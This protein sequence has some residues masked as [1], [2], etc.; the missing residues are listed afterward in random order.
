MTFP[1][2]KAQ[3]L[4]SPHNVKGSKRLLT[5]QHNVG[6][7]YRALE[8]RAYAQRRESSIEDNDDDDDDISIASRTP[9]PPP[10]D[11][12]D[13]D[14]DHIS[15]YDEYVRGPAREVITV[16]TRIKP[17]NKGF[18]LLA[19]MG[20]TE[21]KPLGL[22]EDGR[23]DPIPF[24]IKNDLTGLGKTNQDVRM[25][26]T[27]VSQRRELDSERQT[28]ETEEQRRV[29][30]EHV[31]RRTAL[32]TEISST[33]RA[34]YCELCDKQFKNVAQYDEHTNSYAHHHKARLKDMQANARIIPREELDRRK[35]KERKREEKEL[36]KIAAAA[37]IKMPKSA[38]TTITPTSADAQPGSDMDVEPKQSGFRQAGWASVSSASN[39]SSAPAGQSSQSAG[40]RGG[41]N[42]VG[43]ATVTSAPLPPPSN[44]PPSSGGWSTASNP[45]SSHPSH[46]T[47]FRTGG[48]T[49]L[50]TGSSHIPPPPTHIPLPPSPPP[51]FSAPGQHAAPPPPSSQRGGWSSS[52]FSSTAPPPMPPASRGGWSTP[53]SLPSVPA[54][55]NTP[56]PAA[57]PMA[58][59]LPVAAAAPP[60]P[61]NPRSSWQNFQKSKRK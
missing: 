9:S 44:P 50:D 25:I 1:S 3:D 18:A 23:V 12:M 17:S 16:E 57:P 39:L 41:W 45:P 31:A 58:Q 21:G 54:P 51:E 4:L 19:K 8:R 11:S 7:L 48:W 61:K 20:W 32:D 36:R 22:S 53:G 5:L 38:A 52:G 37:G 29:R 56:L 2:P 47:S 43:N 35:E 10:G 60:P 26:E 6:E 33:L 15:K 42:T 49:S 27:T 28:K 34:F 46:T 55:A 59:R 30:E 14:G 24:Q 40:G 13:V